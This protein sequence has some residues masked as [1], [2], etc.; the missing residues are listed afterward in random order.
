MSRRFRASQP[1][2]GAKSGGMARRRLPL[3]PLAVAAV[4]VLVLAV[5]LVVLLG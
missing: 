1:Y 5:V 2:A 4:L 3:V